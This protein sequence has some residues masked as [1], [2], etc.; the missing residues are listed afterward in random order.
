MC[1][2][3]ENANKVDHKKRP[4]ILLP[5]KEKAIKKTKVFKSSKSL[6]K[7]KTIV[8]LDLIT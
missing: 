7:V 5:G 2:H 1:T 3:P 8:L 4:M 6:E